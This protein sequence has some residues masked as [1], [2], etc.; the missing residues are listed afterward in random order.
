MWLVI[1]FL[2]IPMAAWAQQPRPQ[3]ASSV[4]RALVAAVQQIIASTDIYVTDMERQLMAKDK[5]IAE[6]REKCGD[7][8]KPSPPQKPGP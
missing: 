6:L 1:L 5:E 2:L 3:P 4:E 7:P 8:C